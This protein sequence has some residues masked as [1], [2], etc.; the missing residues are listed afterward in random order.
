MRRPDV[1]CKTERRFDRLHAAHPVP[2]RPLARIV[3]D[4]ARLRDNCSLRDRRIRVQAV[5][6]KAR[7]ISIVRERLQSTVWLWHVRERFVAVA[8]SAV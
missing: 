6:V 3:T 7:T 8:A 2:T 4:N 5:R 1:I